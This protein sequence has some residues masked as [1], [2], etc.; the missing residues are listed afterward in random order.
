MLLQRRRD[1]PGLPWTIS[2][3]GW[4]AAPPTAP[5]VPADE[6]RTLIRASIPE[7][8][9]I[10]GLGHAKRSRPLWSWLSL[11]AVRQFAWQLATFDQIVGRYGLQ[12]GAAYLLERFSGGLHVV[13]QAAVPLSGPL[14]IVANHPGLMDF[15]ALLVGL[16]RSD[17]Y[18][19]AID[20]P[21]FRSLPHTSRHLIYVPQTGAGR[22][23]ILHTVASHLNCG[24]AVLIFPA[25]RLEPDPAVQPG[26]V[27][28]L[29]K[30]SR[31]V[32]LL[33][34]RAPDTQVLPAVVGG[35]RSAQALHHPLTR[36]RRKLQDRERMAALLQSLVPTYHG[37]SV[38]VVF[39]SP[40][41]G[42]ALLDTAPS[43]QAVRRAIVERVGELLQ[44]LP[45]V[46]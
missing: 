46:R 15:A 10:C 7:F 11:A 30:W 39:G 24:H 38:R 26:S 12:R 2:T 5:A 19:L 31:S 29:Q 43:I 13:E 37:V 28:S 41:D 18:I 40:L 35:V 25:G 32:G 20:R 1:V 8:L 9:D 3:T 17:L 42:A 33:L 34:E 16:R 44:A 45:A 36:L 27:E 22:S 4:R 23:S 6:L 21:F 14:L